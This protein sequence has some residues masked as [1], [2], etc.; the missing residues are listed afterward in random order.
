MI[1]AKGNH[2]VRSYQTTNGPGIE[3]ILTTHGRQ[4]LNVF[5]YLN[6]SNARVSLQFAEVLDPEQIGHDDAKL[7]D[8]YVTVRSNAVWGLEAI[9]IPHIEKRP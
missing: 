9:D 1:E 3:F 5:R 8:F 2:D 7:K 4:E 6:R